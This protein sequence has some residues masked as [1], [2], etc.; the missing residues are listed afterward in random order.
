M[1]AS[2]GFGGEKVAWRLRKTS[3]ENRKT[4]DSPTSTKMQ[5][6]AVGGGGNKSTS[7]KSMEENSRERLHDFASAVKKM[8]V[9]RKETLNMDLTK[10]CE[11]EECV[12]GSG[13]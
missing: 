12:G 4:D 2:G 9:T 8:K 13:R 11:R 10:F 3:G 5:R 6:G 1:G 7:F